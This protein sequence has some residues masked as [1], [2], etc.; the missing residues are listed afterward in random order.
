MSFQINRGLFTLDMSDYHAILGV[1]VESDVKEIRKS[2]LTI[3][4]RLHPDSCV[5]NSEQDRQLAAQLLSKLVN[6][7]WEQLSQEKSRTEHLLLLK[8]KGQAAARKRNEIELMSGLAQQMLKAN[9]PDHFYRSALQ[10]L[11]ERQFQ[12]L[13]QMVEIV[14]QLSELNMAYLVSRI[15]AGE[16]SAGAAKKVHISTSATARSAPEASTKVA[17]VPAKVRES[18]ADQYYRRAENFASKGNFAQATLELRDALKLE[19]NNSRCHSLMGMVYLRQNHATMAKIHFNKALAIDPH[20]L[21][22]LDGKQ[23]I[24]PAQPTS[25]SAAKP[26]K[27]DDRNPKSNNGLFGG[28]FSGKKK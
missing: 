13:D 5:A 18:V 24:E 8:L 25:Q 28:L 23:R 19:P 20:D 16:S 4:R 12:Q 7:A 22:A 17:P 11:A 21:M 27:K 9:N 1:S 14:A 6:P 26:A 15:G 2:Y 3:A 10:D